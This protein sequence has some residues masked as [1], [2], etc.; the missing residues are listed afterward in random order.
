MKQEPFGSR[1]PHPAGVARVTTLDLFHGTLR[2]RWP[3]F[4]LHAWVQEASFGKG[5]LL[6]G[7]IGSLCAD[8]TF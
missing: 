3:A 1:Y 5:R 7:P 2:R 4:G 8:A 6:V